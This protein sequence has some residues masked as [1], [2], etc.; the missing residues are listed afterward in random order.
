MGKTSIQWSEHSWNPVRGCSRV[1]EGCRNCYA[2][3][4]V[5]RG[6]PGL[7]SPTTGEPFAIRTPSGP[8]W[9]GEV[10]LIESALDIPLRRR[11]PTTWFVNSMSDLFHESL[12]DEAIDR[13]MAV[14]ILSDRHRST[15][16]NHTMQVLTKRAARAQSY[17][18]DPETPYRVGSWV[19]SMVIKGWR[20][21]KGG[22]DWNPIKPWPPENL[23]L[24]V[25]VEDRA[26]KN[27]I[28]SLRQTP[29][30]VRFLSLEPLLEDIGDLDLTGIH[31]VIIG[32]ESG[33]GARPFDV[34]WPRSIIRQCRAA[35]V[36]AFV[37]Q[38]GAR[39]FDGFSLHRQIHHRSTDGRLYLKLKDHKGG[40][41]SEWPEDLRVR[42]M[43]G[44]G[45]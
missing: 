31:Q 22:L 44:S 40:D 28:D 23:W 39:A 14:T 24:G 34:A 17:M 37:K 38:V 36:A 20:P 25:S 32:G 21:A 18:S 6:L 35:K 26:H 19:T 5:A 4:M 13:V 7:N 33:P 30:A 1:S 11:K 41:P 15:P 3:R 43:P 9:T 45:S 29:A 8:R 27:R 10:E 16:R 2:E 12:P 42:E